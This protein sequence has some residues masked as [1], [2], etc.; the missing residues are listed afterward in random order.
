M[1][2]VL[3]RGVVLSFLVKTPYSSFFQWVELTDLDEIW[4]LDMIGLKIAPLL[5]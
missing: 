1:M 4:W 5:I 3:M 2:I